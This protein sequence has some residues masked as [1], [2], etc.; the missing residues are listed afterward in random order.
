VAARFVDGIT[1]QPMAMSAPAVF[2]AKLSSAPVAS[3]AAAPVV[4][5]H[6]MPLF[7]V[8]VT[9]G[10]L[11]VAGAEV[12]GRKAAGDRVIAF[13]R[14]DA[15]GR[16]RVGELEPGDRV[17]ASARGPR[18]EREIRSVDLLLGSLD[19]A[20]P[21]SAA[22]AVSAF[23]RGGPAIQAMPLGPDRLGVV[24]TL[25]MRSEP[26]E[27]EVR[28]RVSEALS[29]VPTVTVYLDDSVANPVTMALCGSM[30]YTGIVALGSAVGG[31]LDLLCIS[32]DAETNAA[33]AG[34]AIGTTSTNGNLLRS[35]GGLFELN[36]DKGSLVLE[37]ES[38]VYEG[39]LGVVMPPGFSPTNQV[40]PQYAVAPADGDTL[41]GSN[42]LLRL[43]YLDADVAGIDETSIRLF[44]WDSNMVTWAEVDS[45]LS[46]EANCIEA[47][48]SNSGAY[49]LFADSSDDRVKPAAIVDLLATTGTNAWGV[50]LSWTAV[51]DDELDGTA[52]VYV[53]KY[54][55]VPITN[56]DTASTFLLHRAPVAPGGTE[57]VSLHMPDPDT[58][59]YF[60]IRAQ[61]EAGNLGD[62]S[63]EALARSQAADDDGDGIPDQWE[64]SVSGGPASAFD[65][66]TDSDG[67]GLTAREEYALFLNPNSWDTDGDSMSDRWEV[68][69]G[70]DPTEAGD[71]GLDADGDGVDNLQEYKDGT[72]PTLADTDGDGIPDVWEKEQSMDALSPL[73]TQGSDEDADGDGFINADEYTADTD[74]FDDHS[75][76]AITDMFRDGEAFHIVFPGSS[77]RTYDLLFRPALGDGEWQPV[78]NGLWGAG[79]ETVFSD[80]NAAP[81]AGFYRV[82]VRVP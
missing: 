17:Q 42:V 72:N 71:A 2:D 24:V 34:F 43:A 65:P 30:T 47:V 62:I 50:D 64:E 15:T 23:T 45:S 77:R 41:A 22:P 3:A 52:L 66:D 13:G 78:T 61:D 76:L 25:G 1:A 54:A 9:R 35:P 31:T 36:A 7:D 37:S 70:L 11:P 69:H 56:W 18:V 6:E 39:N 32:E 10:G 46:L 12:L 5:D 38:V 19:L 57:T 48:V 58:L 16:V 79:G 14:T 82:R 8:R 21:E 68:D 27:M 51:G 67:D 40:G 4:A 80:T 44:R 33:S 28:L 73:G 59:Y 53:L 26:R 60:A 49:C 29:E 55:T 20:L 63:N 75:K 74:P 81:G